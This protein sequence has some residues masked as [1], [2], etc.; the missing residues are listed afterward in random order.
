SAVGPVLVVADQVDT[1][2]TAGERG[3]AVVVGGDRALAGAQPVALAGEHLVA[4]ASRQV[5]QAVG[6]GDEG[7][8]A[9]VAEVVGGGGA[10]EEFGEGAGEGDADADGAGTGEHLTSC[11]GGA[12][13]GSARG[14]GGGTGGGTGF[15][16]GGNPS[17]WRT[18]TGDPAV[19]ITWQI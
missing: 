12:G 5:E 3:H 1:A 16:H 6:V 11:R 10:G 2:V 13:G 18:G 9:A 4:E 8:V 15:W 14:A 7:A 17:C 19:S